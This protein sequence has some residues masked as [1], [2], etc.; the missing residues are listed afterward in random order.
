MQQCCCGL[1]DSS[2]VPNVR[3]KAPAAWADSREDKE[4]ARNEWV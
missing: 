1:E 2:G 4:I 3:R